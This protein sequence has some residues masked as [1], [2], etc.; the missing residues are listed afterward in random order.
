MIGRK[1]LDLNW[2]DQKSKDL[3]DDDRNVVESMKM[4]QAFV[5]HLSK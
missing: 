1:P 4:L 2:D 3:V 5:V